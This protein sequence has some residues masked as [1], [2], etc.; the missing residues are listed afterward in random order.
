MASRHRKLLEAAPLLWLT[1]EQV[2]KWISITSNYSIFSFSALMLVQFSASRGRTE[3]RNL[4][5]L[6]M[7]R[8]HNDDQVPQLRAVPK[9]QR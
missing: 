3:K 7:A 9:H 6:G 8:L 2:I 5:D 1:S 4:N